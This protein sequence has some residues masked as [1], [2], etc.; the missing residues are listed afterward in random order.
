M[1]KFVIPPSCEK[2]AKP[3]PKLN[4][5][6]WPLGWL[7]RHRAS[8][9]YFRFI[10]S[11]GRWDGSFNI[12][13]EHGMFHGAGFAK[14]YEITPVNHTDKNILVTKLNKYLVNTG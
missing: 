6:I 10:P 13:T 14:S 7:F 5:D 8:G 9:L 3:Y 1:V 2:V 11:G 4:G 12:S